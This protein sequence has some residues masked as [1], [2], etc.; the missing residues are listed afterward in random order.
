MDDTAP[1]LV[2]EAGPLILW[3]PNH[4]Y[5]TIDISQYIIEVSDNC[6]DLAARDVVITS[7]SSDEEEDAQGGGDG[8]TKDDIV[9]TSCGTVD[10]RAER[11][12]SGNGRVYTINLELSDGSENSTPASA[13]LQVHMP[14]SQNGDPAIDDG[15]AYS[16]DSG[17]G[18]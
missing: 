1:T 6:A 10:L 12:G 5:V 15:P 3:S 18:S 16:V 2:A 9:I 7:V 11:E 14:K 13:S 4:E 17:C 8:K